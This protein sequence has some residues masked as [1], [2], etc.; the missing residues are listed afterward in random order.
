MY[1]SDIL[2]RKGTDVITV[3]GNLA[4]AVAVEKLHQKQIGALVVLGKE[5]EVVGILSEHDIIDLFAEYG[6]T[7]LTMP[8]SSVITRDIYVCAPEDRMQ[9]AMA[10]MTQHHVR[11]LPVV[12]DGDLRGLISIG[13]LVKSRLDEARTEAN[14]LRDIAI[15]RT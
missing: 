10:W 12:E 3:H 15:A 7:A 13:D 8:V 14:V 5:D 11:H 4:V 6:D 1:I 9:D 2:K